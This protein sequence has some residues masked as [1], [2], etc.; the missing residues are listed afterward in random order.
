MTNVGCPSRPNVATSVLIKGRPETQPQGGRASKMVA[1]GP[2]MAAAGPKMAAAGPKM[3][4]AGPKMAAAGP[5]MAAAG[6]KM[7]AGPQAGKPALPT[8][9]QEGHGPAGTSS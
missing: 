7:A 4:A 5:K 8:R 2:K 3:A 1:A 9:P 6:P